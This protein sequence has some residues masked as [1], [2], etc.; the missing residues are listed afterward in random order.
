[1]G[2]LL[3]GLYDEA[4]VLHL[5]GHTSSFKATEKR[6]LTERLAPYVITD[7]ST[8]FGQGRTPGGQSR[9]SQGKDLSWV[10][11][12]PELVCEVA[13]DQLQGDR[14]RH[15]STFRRW[16]PDKPST[17]CTYDQLGVA[18]PAELRDLLNPR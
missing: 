9:W 13:F 8:G 1:V 5:V 10:R 4:G 2:S 16:R 11:L 6:E 14:F 15:G 12:R 7:E 3:L 17:E 18:V